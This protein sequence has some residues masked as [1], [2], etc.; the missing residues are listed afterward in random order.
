MKKFYVHFVVPAYVRVEVVAEDEDEAKNIA[1]DYA[2]LDTYGGNGGTEKLFGTYE[3]CVTIAVGEGF[4]E[5][6]NYTFGI[7]VEEVVEDEL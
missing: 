4:L 6:S 7:E 5:G 1:A 2:Y 3:E